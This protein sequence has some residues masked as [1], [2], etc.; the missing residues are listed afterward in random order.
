MR[1][2]ARLDVQA[3]RGQVRQVRR[4]G[5]RR[6]AVI[7]ER[8]LDH[9]AMANGKQL[10][11]ASPIAFFNHLHRVGA[12]GRRVPRAMGAALTLFPKFLTPGNE[13]GPRG[14]R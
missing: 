2:A 11:D 7:G 13:S 8:R 12:I 5:Q 10:R 4:H 14:P 9:T 6:S 1:V 3:R